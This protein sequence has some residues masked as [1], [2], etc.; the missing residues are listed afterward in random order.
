[1]KLYY[2]YIMA[3]LSKRLYTGMSGDLETRVL[4]HKQKQIEGFTK[5]YHINRLVYY[6]TFRDVKE[7]IAREKQIKKWRRE[8]R[9]M[10]IETMN[11]KWRDLSVG[12]PDEWSG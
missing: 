1:M 7:A 11:P 2:V 10:L 9:I 4:Q 6:E 5:R 12:K 8:K 3:S